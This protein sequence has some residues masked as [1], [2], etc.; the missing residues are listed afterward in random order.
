LT[1]HSGGIPDLCVWNYNLKQVKLVEVKG[2]G[3]HLSDSQK[4][5]LDFLFS[6]SIPC[7]V[8]H[9]KLSNKKKDK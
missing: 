4:V 2:Q 5:W 9:V 6:L 8:F 1:A 3:D 7:E